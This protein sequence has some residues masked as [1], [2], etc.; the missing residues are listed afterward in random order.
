M[1]AASFLLPLVLQ[2]VPCRP[3]CSNFNVSVN[4][5]TNPTCSVPISAFNDSFL[6]P[7]LIGAN[8]V[9]GVTTVVG[10]TSVLGDTNAATVG[11]NLITATIL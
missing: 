6:D 3:G 9:R 11:L 5:Q 7:A 1:R 2:V 10:G 8:A 4:A